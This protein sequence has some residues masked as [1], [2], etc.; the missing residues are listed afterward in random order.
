MTTLILR[1]IKGDFVVTGPDIEPLRFKTRREA[2]D[3]CKDALSRLAHQGG[4][5]DLQAPRSAE[6]RAVRREAE[7]DWGTRG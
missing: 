3:W 7:E 1:Y 2:K 4:W 6:R 5:S